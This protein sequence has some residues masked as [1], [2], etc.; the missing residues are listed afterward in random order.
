MTYSFSI[1]M[2]DKDGDEFDNCVLVHCGPTTILRFE[3]TEEM[4]KFAL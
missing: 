4:E 3:N 1:N 2:Y